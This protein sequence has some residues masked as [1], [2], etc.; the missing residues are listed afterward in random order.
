VCSVG[1][2]S[3]E[4]PDLKFELCGHC[5]FVSD[6]DARSACLDWL[7]FQNVDPTPYRLLSDT[8]SGNYLNATASTLHAYVGIGLK[9]G[10][11]YS[12][13]YLKPNAIQKG[14]EHQA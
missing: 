11:P 8:L 10:Q 2:N 13:I 1:L 4:E 12:T 9:R 5:A 3:G 6:L 14:D 7:A